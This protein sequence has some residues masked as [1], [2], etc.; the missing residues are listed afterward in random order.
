[1]KFF[2]KTTLII[3]LT[4]FYNNTLKA[5]ETVDYAAKVN[6]MI[7]TK[8]N[9]LTSGYLYPERYWLFAFPGSASQHLEEWP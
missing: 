3:W 1:M 6:T 7:G 4:V 5:Q 8:G 2:L 9:G